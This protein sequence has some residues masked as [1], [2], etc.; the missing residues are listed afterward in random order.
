MG[1][2]A[3]PCERPS[4]RHVGGRY[5]TA[6]A[7]PPPA[8]C[9][10]RA[11]LARCRRFGCSGGRARGREGH[12]RPRAGA[13]RG[14]GHPHPARADGPGRRQ[15]QGRAGGR[16]QGRRRPSPRP[17]GPSRPRGRRY[18]Q[19]RAAAGAGPWRLPGRAGYQP[20]RGARQ[21]P[22]EPMPDPRPRAGAGPCARPRHGQAGPAHQRCGAGAWRAGA[23]LEDPMSDATIDRPAAPPAPPTGWRR[24]ALDALDERLGLKGL[25]YPVP[26]HANTLAYSLGGL[27]LICFVLMVATGV[28]LTQYY[29]PDPAAA[30]ESVRHII[31]GVTLGSFI[32]AFHYW[33]AMAMIVLVG[34]HLL[35]V[36]ASASF[37]R[38]REGNWVIGVA[39]AATTAG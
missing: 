4:R 18:A 33:G 14:R 35:R 25:Q 30:H 24:R 13:D 22:P 3:R 16:R 19:D 20:R 11:G 34:L 23:G 5:E 36:F 12:P 1:V 39:L 8:A 38:P 29:N 7:G 6:A 17:A 37:K 27:T 9:R 15:D 31:T 10:H 21:A 26:A 2:C 28:F 32:R